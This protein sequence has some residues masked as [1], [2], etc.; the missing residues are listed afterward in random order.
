MEPII[1]KMGHMLCPLFLNTDCWQG[2]MEY[3]IS[4]ETEISKHPFLQ[5]AL[6][7]DLSIALGEE[8]GLIYQSGSVIHRRRPGANVS[9]SGDTVCSMFH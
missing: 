1:L 6:S 9:K 3:A 8:H 2:N 7:M 5:S 4:A